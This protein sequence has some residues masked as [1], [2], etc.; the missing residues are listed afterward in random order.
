MNQRFIPYLLLVISAVCIYFCFTFTMQISGMLQ[1]KA[2][3]PGESFSVQMSETVRRMNTAITT[4][5]SP[6][7]VQYSGIFESPFKL[8]AS[9]SIRRQSS[10]TGAAARRKLFLKGILFKNT[11]LA[12]LEDEKGV[13]YIRGV[14]DTAV[15]QQV[16]K[17]RQNG[18]ILRDKAGSYE[19]TVEEK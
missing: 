14:G 6:E 11:P 4:E 16:I 13:T 9:A 15:G 2:D 5:P 7:K 3:V 10:E 19:L 18:V 8:Y 12:I 1:S 17:I